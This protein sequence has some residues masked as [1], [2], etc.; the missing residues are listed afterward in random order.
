M[1]RLIRESSWFETVMNNSFESGSWN[2]NWWKPHSCDV[3]ASQ[4]NLCSFVRIHWITFIEAIR[5]SW[6]VCHHCQPLFS[7]GFN[8]F[9]STLN[10]YWKSFQSLKDFFNMIESSEDF[11]S[12]SLTSEKLYALFNIPHPMPVVQ[13]QYFALLFLCRINQTNKSATS[14]LLTAQIMREMEIASFPSRHRSTTCQILTFSALVHSLL[15]TEPLSTRI[16]VHEI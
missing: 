2:I 11:P 15:F 3:K 12:I 10:S 5:V 4:C 16:S 7:I 9:V 14:D 6:A 1:R 8:F 13:N